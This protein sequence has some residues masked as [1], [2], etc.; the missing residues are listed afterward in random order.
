MAQSRSEH[1]G[2]AV[3]ESDYAVVTEK[4]QEFLEHFQDEDI[5]GDTVNKYMTVLQGVANRKERVIEIEMDDVF[6]HLGEELAE[7]MRRNA[8]RYKQLLADAIDRAMPEPSEDLGEADV[9]DVLLSSRTRQ[10]RAAAAPADPSDP[11]QYP[12]ALKRRYEVRML[13]R[14]KEKAQPL[15]NVKASAIGHLLT[16][17][18]IVTRVSEVKPNIAI[19]TYTCQKGGT[20]VF[21]EVTNR[22]FMPLFT[23]PSEACCSAS[24]RLH[25]QTRGCKFIKFQEVKIQEEADQAA[26]PANPPL[27]AA[28]LWKA[29]PADAGANGAHAALDDAAPNGRAD[30]QLQRGRDGNGLGHLPAHAV[31]GLQGHARRPD[32]RHLHGGARGREAQEVIP[33]LH[34]RRRD[35]ATHR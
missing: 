20:E 10:Q 29:A 3:V 32:H 23:C 13:P 33:R 14:T 21:Q 18:G 8:Y 34:A 2:V 24:G 9:A 26:P 7:K 6:T 31:R 27:S 15:R 30:P 22:D 16:I 19:A 4:L 1:D 35:G 5:N 28:T 17:K 25:L 11:N 12:P